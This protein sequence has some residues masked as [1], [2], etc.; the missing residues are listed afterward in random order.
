[1]TTSTT[2]R[3]PDPALGL[4]VAGLAFPSLSVVEKFLGERA[5]VP[6]LVYVV[7]AAIV[8]RRLFRAGIFRRLGERVALGL[9][10]A[11]WLALVAAFAVVYPLANSGRL[12]GGSDA[13]DALDISA[14]AILHGKYPYDSPTYLG[15]PITPMPGAVFLAAAFVAL[16]G[17]SAVQ[18]FFWLPLSGALL[19]RTW[20]STSEVLSFF[21]LCLA[22]S[23][24]LLHEMATGIDYTVNGTYVALAAAWALTA[25]ERHSLAAAAFFGVALSSRA[26]FA[27]VLPLV[28]RH[29]VAAHGWRRGA[30]LVLTTCGVALGITLPFYLA[31]PAGFSPLHTIGK[32]AFVPHGAVVLP[33]CAFLL[34]VGLSCRTSDRS[35][36]TLLRD[37]ALVQGFVLVTAEVLWIVRGGQPPFAFTGYG[38]LA[39]GFAVGA[40]ALRRT[41]EGTPRLP[42]PSPPGRS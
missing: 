12:G 3:H 2:A 1:M 24:A 22:A 5:I 7:G 35:A 38:Q 36:Y 21:W 16:F 19:R 25:V 4:L 29:I 31:D 17:K 13:D 20:G 10:A 23:P 39:M 32:L 37:C 14:A 11:T 33:A 30:L 27:L 41:R 28:G 6:Y 34:A 9:S 42:P 18:V 40:A 8:W 26:N 15:N